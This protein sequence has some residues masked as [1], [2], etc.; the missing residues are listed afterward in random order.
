MNIAEVARKYDLTQD[1]LRYYEKIGLIPPV[2]RTSGG[3]RDYNEHDCGWVDFI[4][5]M[6]S[7]GVQIEALAEYVRL[8]QL[9]DSTIGERKEIL[10]RERRRIADQIAEM[11]G[12]LN[13]LDAKIEH[14]ARDIVPAQ[15]ELFA[16][17]VSE[18]THAQ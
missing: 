1:T 3:T 13:R 12:T 7:A 5:C 4:K 16:S 8:C 10:M 17:S 11:Q 9:G 2:N 14:Y 6:R 18:H 15:R